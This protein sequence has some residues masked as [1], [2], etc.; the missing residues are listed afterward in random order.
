MPPG[1]A[2]DHRG[3]PEWQLQGVSTMRRP[4]GATS[5]SVPGRNVWRAGAPRRRLTGRCRTTAWGRPPTSWA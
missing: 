1:E 4:A 5:F 2:L 3:A